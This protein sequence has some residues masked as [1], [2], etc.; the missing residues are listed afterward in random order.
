MCLAFVLSDDAVSALRR[1]AVEDNDRALAGALSQRFVLPSSAAA[2]VDDDDDGGGGDDDAVVRAR[3]APIA[4]GDDDRAGFII[5]A[6]L[7]RRSASHYKSARIITRHMHHITR[8]MSHAKMQPPVS[9]IGNCLG[10][11]LC[12]DS[13]VEEN[14]SVGRQGRRTQHTRCF[15]NLLK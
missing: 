12:L 15:Q 8:H 1:A 10:V 11:I 5:L 6:P 7:S 3:G 14:T 9:W 2:A 4:L 13:G